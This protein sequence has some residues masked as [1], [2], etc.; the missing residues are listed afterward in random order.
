MRFAR[1]SWEDRIPYELIERPSDARA[2]P[3]RTEP[4][5]WAADLTQLLAGRIIGRKV[6]RQAV[7]QALGLTGQALTHALSG[8]T[9]LH[10]GHLVGALE[11]V[12]DS[13]ERFFFELTAPASNLAQ[14]I[15]W[16][17]ALDDLERHFPSEPRPKLS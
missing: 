15:A 7:A 13:P 6:P 10:L 2:A 8:T 12:G 3:L 1:R 16:S 11:V 9:Q 14:Q 17:A 4:E 5:E